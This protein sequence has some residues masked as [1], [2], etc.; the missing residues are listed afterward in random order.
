[1]TT[2]SGVPVRRL[3][4]RAGSPPRSRCTARRSGAG[5]PSPPGDGPLLHVRQVSEGLAPLKGQ[6]VR[7]TGQMVGQDGRVIGIQVGLLHR[8]A[9]EELRVG[10]QVL[11]QGRGAGDED[12]QRRAGPASGPA[13]LLPGAGDGAGV[14]DH[15]AGRHLPDVHAQFQRV[16]GDDGPDGP[17]PQAALNLPP[18]RGQVAAPVAPDGGGVL[19]PRGGP[20]PQVAQEDLGAQAGAGEEDRLQVCREDAVGQVQR[21][22]EERTAEAERRVYQRRVVEEDVLLP[23]GAPSSTTGW[24][25]ASSSRPASSRGWRPWRRRRGSGGRRRRSGRPGAVAAGRWRRGSRTPRG[26]C[27]VRPGR[28]SAGRRRSGPSGCGRGGCPGGAYPGWSPAGAPSGGPPRA[29]RWGY[30]RRRRRRQWAGRGRPAVA[31]GRPAWSWAR[32]L[33]GKR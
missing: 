17:L 15:N 22:Q 21:G 29:G 13:G 25:S 7:G 33:V 10:R 8:S 3:T 32:A 11:V 4:A 9:E 14:A 1:M 24:T 27:G 31:G 26:R 12:D 30:R 18:L 19:P 6:L 23:R 2:T 20:F 16:G 28:P 5:R